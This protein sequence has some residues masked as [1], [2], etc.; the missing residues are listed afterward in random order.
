MD[1]KSDFKLDPQFI[2]GIP[3][4]DIQHSDLIERC[5]TLLNYLEK[6][7]T[8]NEHVLTSIEN[9]IEASRSHYD[10]EENL[11]DMIDFPKKE[12]QKANHR[13]LLGILVKKPENFRKR[14]VD[15]VKKLIR[16]YRDAEQPHF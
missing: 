1:Q 4:I 3:G 7:K 13:V 5:D 16:E 6:E 10:T 8:I 14:G 15:E 9:L 2:T 12:S 11:L